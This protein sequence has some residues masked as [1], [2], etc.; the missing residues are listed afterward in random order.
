MALLSTIQVREERFKT[1]MS[2]EHIKG[3]WV[4]RC[5]SCGCPLKPKIALSANTCP[6][7]KWKE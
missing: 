3:A 6:L 7:K 2:C 1:C 5:N 4:Q